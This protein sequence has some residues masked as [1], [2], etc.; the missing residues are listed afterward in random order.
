MGQGK[1]N[2]NAFFQKFALFAGF[3][4]IFGFPAVIWVGS[5]VFGIKLDKAVEQVF[6][7]V[8]AHS[9]FRSGSSSGS[10]GGDSSDSGGD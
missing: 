4:L 5:H 10:D 9:P 2:F 1:D 7:R 8:F 6:T 3:M